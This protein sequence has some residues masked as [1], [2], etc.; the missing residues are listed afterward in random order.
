MRVILDEMLAATIAEQLRVRGRDAQA[1]TEHHEL[2]NT[3][4]PSLLEALALTG[5]VLVT[6]NVADFAPLHARF[7]AEGRHHAGIVFCKLPRSKKTVGQWV[8]A[9]DTLFGTAGGAADLSDSTSWI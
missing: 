3:D 8:S 4:D 7:L 5:Q 6:D 9:V 1:V 2:R